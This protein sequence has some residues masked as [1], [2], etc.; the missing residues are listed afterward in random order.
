ML[1][2]TQLRKALAPIEALSNSETSVDIE[3]VTVYLKHL[4]PSQDL[5]VQTQAQKAMA[6]FEEDAGEGHMSKSQLYHTAKMSIELIEMIDAGDDI[7]TGKSG[8]FC[9]TILVGAGDNQAAQG[10]R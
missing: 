8:L 6:E 2:L 5:E 10:R 3:G 1:N 9:R 7:A 4:T